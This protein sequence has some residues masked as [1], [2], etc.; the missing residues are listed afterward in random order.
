MRKSL[1]NLEYMTVRK[2]VS[3][4]DVQSGITKSSFPPKNKGDHIKMP[5]LV[6]LSQ[7][8][9]RRLE[10]IRNYQDAK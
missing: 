4:A 10:R 8:G 5:N 9:L 1:P 7:S 2:G 3:Y 6:N